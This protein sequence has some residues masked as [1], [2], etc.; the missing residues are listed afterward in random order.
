MAF[1]VQQHDRALALRARSQAR[2]GPFLCRLS[3][4]LPDAF[5]NFAVPDDGAEPTAADI[6]ALLSTFAQHGRTAR[7]EFLAGCAPVV[8]RALTD[9]GFTVERRSL[10]MA[11]TEHWLTTRRPPPGLDLA[12]P[13]CDAD[14]ERFARIQHRAFGDPGEA[15]PDAARRLARVSARGGL[16]VLAR[17]QRRMVGGGTC[18][19]PVNG[20]GELDGVA[21]E[22]DARRRGT[23]AA[24]SAHLTAQ[25]FRRGYRL[26]WL[27]PLRPE[28]GHVY[29]GIGYRPIAEK[30][31]LSAPS[32]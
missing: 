21:V 18:M 32:T 25:A 8:E 22:E 14:L 15:G 31:R 23:G 30:L 11:C 20:I 27:E 13:S 9:A 28:L 29:A 10:V 7:L 1:D 26:V 3:E 24:V 19:P 17:Y 6:R 12:E 16:V 5:A 4:R 2:A